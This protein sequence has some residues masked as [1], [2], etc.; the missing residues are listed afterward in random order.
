MI[1]ILFN[2]EILLRQTYKVSFVSHR[3]LHKWPEVSLVRQSLVELA[4][5]PVTSNNVQESS[6]SDVEYHFAYTNF[7]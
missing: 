4:N 7:S 3:F 5:F 1:T 6:Y 2:D